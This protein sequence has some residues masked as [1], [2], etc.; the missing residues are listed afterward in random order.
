ML[1]IPVPAGFAFLPAGKPKN[2]ASPP[3]SVRRTSHAVE[4]LYCMNAKNQFVSAPELVRPK[5][6]KGS[7]EAILAT[8]PFLQGLSP[9]QKRILSDCAMLSSF[10]PGEL[11][12]REG[13][14]ANRFYLIHKGKVA[15]ESY[16]RERGTVLIQNIGSGDLLGWSWL[17]PPYYW[18]FD[19]RAVEPV[20]AVFFYGTPLRDEC[21]AD[22]DFGY[23]LLKRMTEVIIKR[24]QGTRRQLLDSYGLHPS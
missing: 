3:I 13:D 9:H 18:H 20:E 24:L 6:Q 23:E 1:V 8:H 14:P 12:F 16:V 17:F 22:H 7:V 19:A 11:I 10:A 21:E 4:E 2:V 15:L 5:A